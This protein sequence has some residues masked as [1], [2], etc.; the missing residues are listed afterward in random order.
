MKLKFNKKSIKELN[1]TNKA[2]P[3]GMTPQVG[4]GAGTT[5]S[6]DFC[7]SDGACWTI[8]QGGHKCWIWNETDVNYCGRF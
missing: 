5:L 7:N 4:G 1:S 2:L 3:S 8:P 6:V